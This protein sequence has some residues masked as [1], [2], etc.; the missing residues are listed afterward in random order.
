MAAG[1]LLAMYAATATAALYM[2]VRYSIFG[3][4][5]GRAMCDTIIIL[6]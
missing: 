3:L 4:M 5:L 1:W 6:N 2:Y